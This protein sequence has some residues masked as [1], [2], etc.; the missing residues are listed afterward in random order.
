[1]NIFILASNNKNIFEKWVLFNARNR[2]LFRYKN[3]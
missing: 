2:G 3:R 1:M